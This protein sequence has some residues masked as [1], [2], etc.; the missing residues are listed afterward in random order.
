MGDYIR[1]DTVNAGR[2][3]SFLED[4]W[5]VIETT[6]THYGDSTEL[7]YH[8]GL[9]SKVLV[10]ELIAIIK[11]FE[12]HGLK[13]KLFENVAKEFGED[14]QEYSSSGYRTSDKT[15]LYMERYEKIV[16]NANKTFYKDKGSDAYSLPN[17]F[18]F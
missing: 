3:N 9:P 6:K 10:N 11:D 4:G 5:E 12:K 14:I 8:V 18:A 2:V 1:I 13:E 7:N 16:N 15:P 17:D